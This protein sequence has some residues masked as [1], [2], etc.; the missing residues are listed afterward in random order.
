[1]I[2]IFVALYGI[3]ELALWLF[4]DFF[5]AL[6]SRKT[7]DN[8]VRVLLF[9]TSVLACELAL[10]LESHEIEYLQIESESQLDRAAA[11]THLAALSDS[12]LDNLMIS[13][14]GER[15]MNIY[16]QLLL[17]NEPRNDSVFQSNDAPWFHKGEHSAEKVFRQL[18]H[19]AE[20]RSC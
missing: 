3:G 13:R 6:D 7:N 17:C 14:T 18:F 5:D 4:R 16:A 8:N 10:L 2:V 19:V 20:E 11:F 15:M 12:D 9:G 1:M